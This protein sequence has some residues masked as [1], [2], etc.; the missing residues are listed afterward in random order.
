[1]SSPDSVE[2]RLTALE[3]QVAQLREQNA[4]IASDASAARTLAAGADRDVSEVRAELRAHTQVLNSLRETQLEQGQVLAEHGQLLAGQGQML[5]GQK[6]VLAE[7]GQLLVGQ[8][9][10]LVGQ[11][12]VLTDQGQLLAEH[13]QMLAGQ[14][15]VLAE[16]GQVLAGQKQVLIDQ[17]QTMRAGFAG[18]NAGMEQIVAL[19]DRITG[20][21]AD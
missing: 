10:M 2:N 1:M 4:L 9:Q 12:Q 6:Q 14:G 17:G 13:G 11:K 3:R 15:Q 16:H 21:D 7:H 18:V 20:P 5:A 19:L 8:E